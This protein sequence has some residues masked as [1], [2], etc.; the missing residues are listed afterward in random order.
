MISLL[1][2]FHYGAWFDARLTEC[3]AS[4][5]NR[6]HEVPILTNWFQ[7]LN[8]EFIKGAVKNGQTI[9]NIPAPIKRLFSPRDR[10]P[11]VVVSG[12][13]EALE[14]MDIHVGGGAYWWGVSISRGPDPSPFSRLA[15]H[16]TRASANVI[17]FVGD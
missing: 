10:R 5:L 12:S 1:I 9:T 7:V 4:R 3:F 6:N 8:N 17:C 13:D 16:T 2:R 15:K 14:W 11:V